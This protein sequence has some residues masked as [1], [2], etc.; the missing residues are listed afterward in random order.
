LKQQ[1][2]DGDKT[3]SSAAAGPGSGD[4]Q[5]AVGR[6]AAST[7]RPEGLQWRGRKSRRCRRRV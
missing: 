5:P 1:A 7:S 4:R 6:A 3:G 2:E